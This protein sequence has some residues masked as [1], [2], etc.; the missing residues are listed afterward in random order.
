M[1]TFDEVMLLLSSISADDEMNI[2]N[3]AMLELLY[4]TGLRVSE[5]I[6]L[7]LSDI[8]LVD[9]FFENCWYKYQL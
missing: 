4:A 9:C 3:R 6:N 7:K 1:F 5:L 8:N 2:R